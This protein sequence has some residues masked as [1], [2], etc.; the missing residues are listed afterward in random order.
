MGFVVVQQAVFADQIP[1]YGVAKADVLLRVD[2]GVVAEGQGPVVGGTC[3]GTPYAV[4]Q[5]ADLSVALWSGSVLSPACDAKVNEDTN[6]LKHV[7]LFVLP[8]VILSGKAVLESQEPPVLG[9]ITV[10][11]ARGLLVFVSVA[12]RYR[13]EVGVPLS[14]LTRSVTSVRLQRRSKL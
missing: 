11:G 9:I 5:S 8:I 14:N 6:A 13:R 10:R 12:S 4:D 3:Q 7:K 1:P 2:G